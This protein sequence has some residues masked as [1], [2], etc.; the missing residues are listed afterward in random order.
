MSTFHATQMML[1]ATYW[2]NVIYVHLRLATTGS[3]G[4]CCPFELDFGVLLQADT[5]TAQEK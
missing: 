2:N 4:S 3:F 1:D 5:N